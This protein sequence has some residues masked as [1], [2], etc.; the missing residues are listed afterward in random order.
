VMVNLPY[1]MHKADARSV[2]GIC[3]QWAMFM[4][5]KYAR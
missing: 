1:Y 4:S 2:A 3:S 5:A